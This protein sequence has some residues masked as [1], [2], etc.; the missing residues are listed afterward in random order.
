MLENDYVSGRSVKLLLFNYVEDSIDKRTSVIF[1]MRLSSSLQRQTIL[2]CKSLST[3]TKEFAR[4]VLKKEELITVWL[5]I[6]ANGKQDARMLVFNP[7]LKQRPVDEKIVFLCREHKLAN[8][9][10]FSAKS[11][12][13]TGGVSSQRL[14]SSSVVR[15]KAFEQF[16]GKEF[17]V[18]AILTQ[19]LE[20]IG[21]H[22]IL[23][24]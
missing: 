12:S 10:A 20:H 23:P 24:E 11:S 6:T 14:H 4:L 16:K 19:D 21:M 5:P 13:G 17:N 8:H 9:C 15:N 22:N 18:I 2:C 1:G 3:A 7:L